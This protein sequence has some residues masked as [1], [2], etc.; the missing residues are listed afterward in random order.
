M[1]RLPKAFH[2]VNDAAAR[3]RETGNDMGD[4]GMLLVRL[5]GHDLLTVR[6]VG[7][8]RLVARGSRHLVGSGRPRERNFFDE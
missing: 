6:A 3:D 2:H 4:Y 5:G 1:D 8:A 7:L